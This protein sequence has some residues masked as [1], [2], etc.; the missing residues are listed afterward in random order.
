MAVLAGCIALLLDA[1]AESATTTTYSVQVKYLAASANFEHDK[2]F[3]VRCIITNNGKTKI[4]ELVVR[5][6]VR[7]AIRV[8]GAG[9]SNRLTWSFSN[10]KPGASRSVTVS[11]EVFTFADRLYA[12]RLRTE[13]NGAKT[14]P[15]EVK[16][17]FWTNHQ[18]PSTSG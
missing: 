9:E 14:K 10:M 8:Q 13:V 6:W 11:G 18:P 7:P 17:Y 1:R 16:F 15:P 4:D 3:K 12:H 2:P 5:Y